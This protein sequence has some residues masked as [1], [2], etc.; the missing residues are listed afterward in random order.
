MNVTTS[1]T[2]TTAMTVPAPPRVLV[3]RQV[4]PD[5]LARLR[6]HFDV[7]SNDDDAPWGREQLIERLQGCAG[8]FITTGERIDAAR[9]AE[10]NAVLDLVQGAMSGAPADI[11]APLDD[12]GFTLPS[13]MDP[14]ALAALAG[15]SPKV[16]NA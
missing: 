9:A 12:P 13:R 1:M 16:N 7:R 5:V 15:R 8:A 2:A 4:F 3:A 11:D 14:T 6:L 10:V